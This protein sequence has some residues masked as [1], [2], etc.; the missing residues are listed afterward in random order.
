LK[1][2]GAK[3]PLT[4]LELWECLS[5]EITLTNYINAYSLGPFFV[6]II[7]RL[8]G[9]LLI[10]LA[11]SPLIV[12]HAVIIEAPMSNENKIIAAHSKA[13]NLVFKAN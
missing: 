1:L 11:L 3:H 2:L 8:T 4:N 13:D 12:A 9:F 7:A 5:L 6:I 10:L